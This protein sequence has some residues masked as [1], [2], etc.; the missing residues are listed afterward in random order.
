MISPMSVH[1][2][3]SGTY[4]FEFPQTP[5]EARAQMRRGMVERFRR[6]GGARTGGGIPAVLLETT[7]AKSGELRHAIVGLIPEGPESWLTVASLSGSAHH[8]QWLYNLAHDPGAVI[9]FGDGRRV[10]V[11]AETPQGED[12]DAAWELLAR[13]APEYVGYRSKT[14]RQIPVVR[15]RTA[16]AAGGTNG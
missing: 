12:L 11:Q 10:P 2:P 16:K 3:P 14:D 4:G 9:E 13:E 5:P 15:L 7:G 6:D 1:V 8:P